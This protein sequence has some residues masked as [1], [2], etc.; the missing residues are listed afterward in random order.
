MDIKLI[1]S[2][3]FILFLAELG[4]K[5]QFAA[6]AASAGSNK[7]LS[8]LIGAVL[9]LTISSIIAVAAGSIIGN[10]IP[11]RYIKIAAGV[12]FLIF[13][14]IYIKEGLTKE[15]FQIEKPTET[16]RPKTLVINVAKQFELQELDILKEA[17]KKITNPE[18][19]AVIEK[20]IQNDTNHF[21][22]LNNITGQELYIEDNI[23]NHQYLNSVFTDCH[24]DNQT[25]KE[26]ILREEAMADFYRILSEKTKIPSAKKIFKQLYYEEK[27]H[28]TK[29]HALIKMPC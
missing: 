12:L 28:S 13:G 9:A 16:T 3:F 10:I 21:K 7:P 6:I 22:S 27:E 23:T 18:T 14:I 19:K 29:I 25:L 15:N 17:L 26:L 2:T 20:I 4:D 11:I 5:T 8:I 24:E 1:A